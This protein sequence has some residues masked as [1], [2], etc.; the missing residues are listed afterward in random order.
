MV[1]KIK[2]KFQLVGTKIKEFELPNS[3]GET[4]N[5]RNLENKKNVIIVL[6]RSIHWPYC[7]WHAAKLR[8][9]LE[10]FEELD[11]YLYTIL[12]DRESNAKKM[13]EK[14]AR[15]YP[16]FYDKTKDVVNLL[17]QEVI[18]LKLGRMPAL[19]IVDKKGI[20]QYAY[21]SD[22]MQDIPENETILEVLRKINN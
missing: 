17:N 22:S 5:I 3:R 19:L 13:E 15:R 12:A 16:V 6:F 8:K 1:F 2:D 21:Y 7:R 4:L 18:A 14:Y 20:I 11:G 9:D 10:K